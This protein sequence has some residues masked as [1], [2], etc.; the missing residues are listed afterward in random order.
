M[1]WSS[2]EAV[3][4]FAGSRPI[5]AVTYPEDDKYGSI[6]H[7]IVINEEVHF[8]ANPFEMNAL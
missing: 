2:W 5:I 4:L 7:L 3:H 1:V 6:S 8:S